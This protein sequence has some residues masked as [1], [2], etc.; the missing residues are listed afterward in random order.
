VEAC[1]VHG[2]YAS[3]MR[4]LLTFAAFSGMRPG[5]LMALDWSDINLPA[6][7]VTVSKRLYRGSIDLPK[8]NKVREIALTPPARDALLSLPERDGP[9]F[10][11]KAGGR[12][13]RRCC[14]PTGAR[15][16]L[17][18]VSASTGTW[19]RSTSASITSRWSWGCRTT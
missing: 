2:D 13:A 9:V 12:I 15:C 8:S 4:A 3:R 16:K 19:L 14:R 18:P 17:R 1:A 11:S 7:R 5:E 10:L 6:L